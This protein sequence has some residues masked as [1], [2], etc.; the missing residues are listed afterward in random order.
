VNVDTANTKNNDNSFAS[1]FEESLRV[2]DGVKEGDIVKGEVVQVNR[3]HVV[4]DIG[5]KS[6]GT[7]DIHEFSSIN[8][9]AQVKA[10]DKIDVFVESREDESGHVVLSKEK[11]D[12]LK[13]WDEISAAA[14][15]DELVEGT[16]VA[17]VKGGL[18]VD[19]G[20]KAF[21]PGSQVDLRP[22]RNLDKLIGEKFKF[23][24]I[25]FNKKRG[26]IVLSRRAL[27]EKERETLKRDTLAKL[28]EGAILDG[29]VKNITEYGAFIDLGGIDGLLHITD[30]SWGRVQH[31]SE[32]L[33]VSDELK[34]KVL[35]YDQE[36]ER[37]SLGLKQMQEDP[38]SS[39]PAKFPTGTRVKGKVVSLT[40]YGAFVEI[41][42]G[43][44][45]LVHVSEMSWTKRV[46]HPSKLVNIGDT[47][48]AVVLDVDAANRRISIGMKQ[49]EANPWTLLQ[50]KYPVGA[51]INGK[52][53]NITD[54][55]IFVGVEEGIDGLVHVSDLSWT[56][57]VKHPSELYQKGDEVEAVVLSIDVE[58]ERFS[59]GIKQLE[60]DPWDTLPKR[61]PRGIKVKGKVMKVTDY[62]AFVEIEPGIDGL[63]H[64]SEMA[65]QRVDSPAAVVK[66]GDEI[67]VIILDVDPAERRISLSLKAARNEDGSY[68]QYLGDQ[69]Q[70]SS[71]L[72]D[73]FA[74]KLK[75]SQ[76]DK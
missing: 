51:V 14:E 20:V 71:R 54:F 4:V 50:E 55:G 46:K 12:K 13:V 11:A 74:Q 70:G 64:V 75:Q 31:P 10:G 65:D 25:K 63:V 27:L 37:V 76:E 43:V 8:G 28:Q 62:G 29:I 38:W 34:V 49:L 26:N 39:A 57:R 40:D 56:H 3:D 30:M 17:R 48:E 69:N 1:L 7:I 61:F 35:K 44:E 52:V 41:E 16:I 59:L 2:R 60:D 5:Y 45:G 47:V 58:N 19:I 53:R 6:E 22:I 18:S 42:P 21:L 66:P 23:K 73:V 15:R 67:E 72:G 36:H 68:T 33:N 24:V 9:V 32:V